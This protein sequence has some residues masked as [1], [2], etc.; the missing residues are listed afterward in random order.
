MRPVPRQ[1]QGFGDRCATVEQHLKPDTDIGE[2]R[3]GDNHMPAHPER[4]PDNIGRRNQFLKSAE[5][6]NVVKSVLAILI[7]TVG[8]VALV[9]DKSTFDATSAQSGVL[10]DA[11]TGDLPGLDEA[12]EKRAIAGT[13]VEDARALGNPV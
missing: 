13:E 9:N 7:Q 1:R 5:Q 2:I 12:L 3:V 10:F 8:N 11:F 4:F 6:Q